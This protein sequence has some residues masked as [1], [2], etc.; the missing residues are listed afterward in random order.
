MQV[1][2]LI[3]LHDWFQYNIVNK[4]I[5][6]KYTTLQQ[7]LQNNI[8]ASTL[9]PNQRN[10]VQLKPY[11]NDFE[12]LQTSLE[13]I[14]F[15]N[16]GLAQES[17]LESMGAHQLLGRKGS[18]EIGTVALNSL[19][20]VTFNKYC[21]D[22]VSTLNSTNQKLTNIKKQLREVFVGSDVIESDFDPS[23]E[24]M[25]R[26][27]FQGNSSLSNVELFESWGKQWKFIIDHTGTP[28]NTTAHDVKIVGASK[29]SVIL[30]LIVTAS[31]YA[32]AFGG[33]VTWA[34]STINSTLEI[35]KKRIE[36][37]S[38]EMDVEIKKSVLSQLHQAEEKIKND[39][40]DNKV[41]E[42][43]NEVESLNGETT[44]KLKSAVRKLFNFVDGGGSIDIVTESEVDDENVAEEI[45][46]LRDTFGEARLIQENLKVLEHLKQ[47][48]EP[49][50]D[51]D[52]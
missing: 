17:L 43:S 8:T 49:D 13:S 37:E 44:N 50:F 5:I 51:N 42:I 18:E 1:S 36:M 35:R 40:I 22:A 19:D 27:H 3:H 45:K 12:V 28:Y 29:G 16:L 26:V 39:A 23:K 46:Q 34:L 33:L 2:E 48:V 25:L 32:V 6:D 7:I 10:R 14:D 38:I 21:S 15:R 31:P 9:S 20:I 52:E 11:Q 30:E 24:V 4:G 41:V 47:D